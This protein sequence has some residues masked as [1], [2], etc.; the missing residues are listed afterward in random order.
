MPLTP[1]ATRAP[2][3][4]L[5]GYYRHESDRREWVLDLFE[6]TSGDYDRIERMMAL[7]TG[8]WYRRRALRRA[9]LQP[10][11]MVLDIGAGTGLV[12]CEAARIVGDPKSVLGVD[13][14]SAMIDRARVPAGVRIVTGSAE[15]IPAPDAEADFLS[16][17]YALRHVSDLP[18]A[19]AEFLRV[20]KPGGRVCLLEMTRPDG[21]WSRLL[22]KTYMRRVVPL[23]ARLV[24]RNSGTPTL[25]RYYWDTIEMCVPPR[26][27]HSAL[28]AAGFVDID[29]HVELGV[30]SEYRA[31]KPA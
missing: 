17:G 24:A 23:A 26:S 18:T 5:T 2:H 15:C 6:R 1:E 20:L 27:I 30:F 19:F 12:A 16:M 7:G 11:M 4:P 3:P 28:E 29:R 21:A 22:L 10:G 31:R 13:P 25:M 9:G 8:S 14:C